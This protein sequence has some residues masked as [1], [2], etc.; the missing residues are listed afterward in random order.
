MYSFGISLTDIRERQSCHSVVGA[1]VNALFFCKCMVHK[2]L[3]DSVAE[4]ERSSCTTH[5]QF[6]IFRRKPFH[7]KT[8]NGYLGE[9]K[10]CLDHKNGRTTTFRQNIILAMCVS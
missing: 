8:S 5:N 3:L 4:L 6:H 1:T 2:A 9:I 7:C 10:S